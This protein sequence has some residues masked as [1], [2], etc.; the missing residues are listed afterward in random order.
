MVR[1]LQGPAFHLQ[2]NRIV[3]IAEPQRGG[4]IS[5]MVWHG[6]GAA[7]PLLYAPDHQPQAPNG[8]DLF[9]CWPMVPFANRCFGG[10]LSFDGRSFELPINEPQSG[11]AMHGF[12]WQ[13]AWQVDAHDANSLEMSHR[14][15]DAFGPFRYRATMRIRLSENGVFIALSVRNQA[16][17]PMPFGLGLHPWFNWLPGTTLQFTARREMIFDADFHPLSSRDRGVDASFERATSVKGDEVIALNA[18]GWSHAAII[19]APGRPRISIS[20]SDSLNAPLL[21]SPPGTAFFCFEPQSHAL[22]A[23][24]DVAGHEAAPLTLLH[25]G[26]T[27]EGWMRIDVG[28]AFGTSIH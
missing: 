11:N 27:L 1:A 14:C 16:E 19:D 9:G 6:D 20:A 23:P 26:E 22:G 24:S 2:N 18:I 12:G 5:S 25:P 7:V 4:L 21:W 15:S 28:D 10:R 3:L 8:I 17:A 13:S